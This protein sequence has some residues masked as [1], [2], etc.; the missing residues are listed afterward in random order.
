LQNKKARISCRRTLESSWVLSVV[1]AGFAFIAGT[2]Y[3]P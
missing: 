1:Y 3:S 2:L